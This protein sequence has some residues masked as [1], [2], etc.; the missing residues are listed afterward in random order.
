LIGVDFQF[1]ADPLAAEKRNRVRLKA[2]KADTAGPLRLDISRGKNNQ[3]NDRRG[4]Q[5]Q[6]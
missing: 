6:R 4:W 1:L 3:C 5:P 2:A